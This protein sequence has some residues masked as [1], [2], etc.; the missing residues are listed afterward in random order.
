MSLPRLEV[1]DVFRAWAGRFLERTRARISWPQLKVIRAIERCRTAALGRHR[2][3]CSGC[4]KDFGFSFN[5]CRNRHCPKCQTQARDRWVAARI[6]EL[7]PL[8]YFHVVFTVPHQLSP[9]M[10]QN[11]R[12]LY[13]L[14]FRCVADTLLEVA[15]N[16]KRLGAEIGFL[17]VLHTW[18]QTLIHHPH[19]HCVVPAGGFAPGRARWIKPK[20]AGFFLPTAVL[21][22]VFRGKFVD[23][24]RN[25]FRRNKLAFHGS[26]A[27]LAEPRSFARLLRVLHRH[28]WVVY[29]K[30]PFGGPEHVL[31]YLA[32][33]THR[34]AISNHRLI[35]MEDGKVTF[36][37]KDYAHGGKKRKMTLAAEEFIRRFLLHV[38]PKGLAR[39]RHYG[40]MANRVR[41][42]RAALCR[43][44]L[45]AD[46]PEPATATVADDAHTRRCP[47]C[48]GVIEVVEMI[49]PRELRRRP[50]S[51]QRVPNTS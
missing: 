20:S 23:A 1:A 5:S 26:L 43:A 34:V 40:W 48:G 13:D 42:E 36:R 35:G 22:D 44:L 46:A 38:L 17:C 11:K 51:R 32:R 30:K 15:A 49:V 31:H 16:P 18:G 45:A 14:L 21:S 10:L 6:G 7:V 29:A 9:L 37:W 39:I 2:D 4:G 3:V 33:Y 41:G 25:L 19:I 24:L 27:E 12:T 47:V 28:P 8:N 50:I